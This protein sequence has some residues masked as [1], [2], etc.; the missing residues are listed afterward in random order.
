LQDAVDASL[1]Q[2]FENERLIACTEYDGPVCGCIPEP[3][4]AQCIDGSCTAVSQA[5]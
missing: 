1:T 3:M 2:V 5:D 4:A